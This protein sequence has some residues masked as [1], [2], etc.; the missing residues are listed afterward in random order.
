MT[1]E[2]LLA[3]AFCVA[4]MFYASVGHGGASAYLAVMAFAGLIPEVMRAALG[5]VLLAAAVKFGSLVLR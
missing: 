5:L 1:V 3:V 2:W 4:A